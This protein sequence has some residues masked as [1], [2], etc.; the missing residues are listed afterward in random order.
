MRVQEIVD[1]ATKDPQFADQ[2]HAKALAAAGTVRGGNRAQGDAW[3][4]LLREFAETPEELGRLLGPDKTP[5]A[6]SWWTTATTT[7]VTTS[8]CTVTV[9]SVGTT[10]L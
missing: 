2:L 8:T 3:E 9:T 4:A 6:G 1:R 10:I 7:T 5:L